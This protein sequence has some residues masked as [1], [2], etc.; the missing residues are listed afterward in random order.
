MSALVRSVGVD[1]SGFSLPELPTVA[2]VLACLSGVTL[3]EVLAG[4]GLA[5]LD[6]EPV[7]WAITVA[8][9]G[10]VVYDWLTT[11][12]PDQTTIDASY[13]QNSQP[14]GT[15]LLTCALQSELDTDG[16][17]LTPERLTEDYW[18][19]INLV[20]YI[21]ED[22]YE[23]FYTI[24]TQTDGGTQSERISA[25]VYKEKAK[26]ANLPPKK[27]EDGDEATFF[28][29]LYDAAVDMTKSGI[30]DINTG[31]YAKGI[32][33]VTAGTGGSYIW[34]ALLADKILPIEQFIDWLNDN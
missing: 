11:N 22:D 19:A 29:N 21:T 20:A 28:Q 5:A 14:I 27:P 2:D 33:E 6:L 23:E 26:Y 18:S 4:L 24:L 32:A 3:D 17:P 25:F 31:N 9:A 15:S 10:V 34:A 1:L 12:H 13:L 7:G 30:E 8:A 16:N